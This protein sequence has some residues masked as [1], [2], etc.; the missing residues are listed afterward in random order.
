MFLTASY[1]VLPC[2]GAGIGNLRS[3]PKWVMLTSFLKANLGGE[4]PRFMG[5]RG[6]DFWVSWRIH[7]SRN[8]NPTHQCANCIMLPSYHSRHWLQSRTPPISSAPQADRLC[9]ILQWSEAV[10]ATSFTTSTRMTQSPFK[11]SRLKFVRPVAGRR[12]EVQ[13]GLRHP[14]TASR[15]S[16]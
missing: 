12:A 7:V 2:L 8:Q 13:S 10:L 16:R 11:Q 9:K 5:E 4:G 6:P 14:A 15:I 1:Y 3:V